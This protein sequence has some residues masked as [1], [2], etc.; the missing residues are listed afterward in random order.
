MQLLYTPSFF[1]LLSFDLYGS[2]SAENNLN[3][4][5]K[6]KQERIDAPST[7]EQYAIVS[8]IASAEAN[9]I[10][11]TPLFNETVD[12]ENRNLTATDNAFVISIC[13]LLLGLLGELVLLILLI[14]WTRYRSGASK[15][16]I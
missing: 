7:S 11:P 4:Q 16:T 12:T 10:Y 3:V 15:S 13:L 6:T 8:P 14:N 9:I 5:Y 2:I 1:G